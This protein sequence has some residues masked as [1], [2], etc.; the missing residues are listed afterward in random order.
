MSESIRGTELPTSYGEVINELLDVVATHS[1]IEEYENGSTETIAFDGSIKPFYISSDLTQKL[2]LGTFVRARVIGSIEEGMGIAI[3]IRAMNPFNRNIHGF[4]IQPTPQGLDGPDLFSEDRGFDVF[5]GGA[6]WP[7]R[8][9]VYWGKELFE[10]GAEG[11][12]K[13][14]KQA[15]VEA[16]HKHAGLGRK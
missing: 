14:T 3:I 7:N 10:D 4:F 1:E 13:S 16:I 11:A 8:K 6:T 15:L 2:G 5:E 12:S 9:G